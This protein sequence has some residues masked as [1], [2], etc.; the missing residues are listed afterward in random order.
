[1][2]QAAPGED[3][4][5]AHKGDEAAAAQL[6]T[7]GLRV[8]HAV[9]VRFQALPVLMPIREA[10]FNIPTAPE[11]DRFS[12]R[13]DAE[14]PSDGPG[15]LRPFKQD[16]STAADNLCR[17]RLQTVRSH[18][19]AV[20]LLSRAPWKVV[21]QRVRGPGAQHS[22][23]LC[24]ER[25]RESRLESAVGVDPD[26]RA[27]QDVL[28]RRVDPHVAAFGARPAA[29]LLPN[30]RTCQSQRRSLTGSTVD[31]QSNI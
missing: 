5:V 3:G 11:Q 13:G 23:A 18:I 7:Q 25:H 28:S 8:L 1:M 30:I 31:R 26:G 22:P 15:C 20:I 9:H 10:G 27:L 21:H 6:V 4:A 2:L 29:A 16:M 12:Q 17:A 14:M 19:S 24:G